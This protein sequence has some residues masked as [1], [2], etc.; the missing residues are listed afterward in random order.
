MKKHP[1][2]LK[3]GQVWAKIT[4]DRNGMRRVVSRTVLL[5]DDDRRVHYTPKRTRC[6]CCLS[7]WREWSAKASLARCVTVPCLTC[8]GIGS[9]QEGGTLSPFR[10]CSVCHGKGWLGGEK[11]KKNEKSNR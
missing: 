6:V 9:A 2:T 3:P 1:K 10:R 7:E 4:T 5:V 8:N 11:D